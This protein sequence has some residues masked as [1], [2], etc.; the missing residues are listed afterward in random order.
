M[1]MEDPLAKIVAGKWDIK[2]AAA[3]FDREQEEAAKAEE[4]NTKVSNALRN[5]DYAGALAIADEAI[6]AT[7]SME[8]N[9]AAFKLSMLKQL[10]RTNDA[11]AYQIRLVETVLNDNAMG[12]NQIAW[13]IV[14]PETKSKP[15]ADEKKLALK[16]ALRADQLTK[17]KDAA[18][19][20]TLAAA[21][22]ANG[23][24]ERAITTQKRAIELARGTQFEKDPSF[25][26][27]LKQYS[28]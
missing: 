15:S 14:D 22:F 23:D 3:Q 4:F 12:L 11:M 20:D 8:A 19:S 18:I 10:N 17:S 27:H 9:L 2:A 6:K 24:R 1:F 21:Y 7:P 13:Q 5:R 16:A 26:Q 28:K 25:E